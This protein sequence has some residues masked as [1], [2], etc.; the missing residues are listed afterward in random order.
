MAMLIL[1][2]LLLAGAFTDAKSLVDFFT[3]VDKPMKPTSEY[4][5]G[6]LFAA[7]LLTSFL[8]HVPH[9]QKIDEFAKRLFQRIGNIPAEMRIFS[10]EL[11]R[12]KLRPGSGIN[13]SDYGELGVK[14]DW[15]KLPESS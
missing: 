3:P 9:L 4:L 6:P 8:P 15:L 12:A 14:A 2:Y 5:P 7:L 10:A 13:A 1:V 11:E